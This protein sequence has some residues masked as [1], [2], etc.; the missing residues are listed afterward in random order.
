MIRSSF[1]RF[2]HVQV[3]ALLLWSLGLTTHADTPVVRAVLFY[4]PTCP[5]CHQVI[6]EDLPP[7]FEK[8]GD[9]LQMIGVNTADAAGTTLFNATADKFK[10][11]PENLGVPLLVVGDEVLVGSLDIPQQFPG[12][13]E[14]YLAAGG[15]DWPDIHGLAEAIAQAE[16]AQPTTVTPPATP[17]PSA[18][19]LAPTL[20]PT[21]APTAARPTPTPIPGFLTA[22]GISDGYHARFDRDPIGNGLAVIVLVGMVAALGWVI[23]RR[24]WRAWGEGAPA[25]RDRGNQPAGYPLDWAVPLLSIV[26]L[27]IASYLA[28]VETQQ[29]QAVCGPVG[30]CNAVQQSEYARLFGLIPIG[31]VGVLGYLAILGAWA[32]YRLSS[33]QIRQ[34]AGLAVCVMTAGGVLFSIYLTFLEPFVIGATCAWCLSSAVIMTLLLLVSTA[35]VLGAGDSVRHDQPEGERQTSWGG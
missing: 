20:V 6:T 26:G 7:L 17:P 34:W 31:V 30:D 21:S 27:G 22:G 16:A 18:A 25:S 2:L 35:Q 10:I 14:K 12:L 13:I 1:R 32:V 8:Y 28:Y 3:L 23:V 24:P 9:R 15:V 33:G 11:P 5:H 29:V 4:S 19:L